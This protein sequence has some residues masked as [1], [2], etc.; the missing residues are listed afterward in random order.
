MTGRAPDARHANRLIPGDPSLHA[1][2][3]PFQ[4]PLYGLDS[5]HV[6]IE[7]SPG[8]RSNQGKE[9]RSIVLDP[10]PG[11]P[12]P[13][14]VG[15]ANHAE[16]GQLIM[17]LTASVSSVQCD[18]DSTKRVPG[19]VGRVH[20]PHQ[21]HSRLIT[22]SIS[23]RTLLGIVVCRLKTLCFALMPPFNRFRILCLHN[24]V[25]GHELDPPV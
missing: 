4:S 22:H 14:L 6:A 8:A 13:L 2:Q 23:N 19:D 15:F 25:L 17:D 16:H 10:P 20:D 3:T 9:S 24:L 11:G 18:R 7:K 12:R 21:L 1:R 5:C